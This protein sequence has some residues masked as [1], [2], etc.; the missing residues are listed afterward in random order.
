[1][2]RHN[3]TMERILVSLRQARIPMTA[4][5]LTRLLRTQPKRPHPIEREALQYRQAFAYLREEWTGVAKPI[6]LASIEVLM[7]VALRLP[8]A[9][10]SRIMANNTADLNQLLTYI[11]TKSDHPILIAGVTHAA[12]S[13]SRLHKETDGH[14]TLL[15]SSLIFNKFGYDCRG[16]VAPESI[17]FADTKAYDYALSSA[18]VYGQMT[19]WLEYYTHSICSS[20]AELLQHMREAIH[21]PMNKSMLISNLNV[22][23]KNILLLLD[24]QGAT[25]TNRQVQKHFK[26]SQITASRDLARLVSQGFLLS[27]GKGRSTFYTIA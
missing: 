21:R 1:M 25:I 26:I 16:M 10:I 7:Y 23:Q 5:E 18:A 19:L 6:T 22:R 13:H 4:P 20:Y 11:E 15:I 14:M 8:S 17:L 3:A 2:L 27:S 24:M 12:L 9:R